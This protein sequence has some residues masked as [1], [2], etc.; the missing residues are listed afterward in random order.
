MRRL[1]AIAV[2][3]LCASCGSVTPPPAP[4]ADALTVDPKLAEK[5]CGP[6]AAVDEETVV[7]VGEADAITAAIRLVCRDV[8]QL[9]ASEASRRAWFIACTESDSACP[10]G[11]RCDLAAGVC[12]AEVGT[13][14]L[15]CLPGFADCN[16]KVEDGCEAD[17]L[18]EA[19]HCGECSN[20]CD[21]IKSEDPIE[22]KRGRCEPVCRDGF[23][24]CNDLPSDGCEVA[25]D[26]VSNCGKCKNDCVSKLQASSGTA[27]GQ[28]RC[29]KSKAASGDEATHTCALGCVQGRADCIALDAQ[30]P[31]T[32]AGCETPLGTLTD[33]RA[34]GD[35]CGANEKCTAEGCL[36][37]SSPNVQKCGEKL[38]SIDDEA[39]CGDCDTD[40]VAAFPHQQV[41]CKR[42]VADGKGKP[43]ATE[44]G[45]C[46]FATQDA[47]ESPCPPYRMSC[48]GIDASCE[49]TFVP[50]VNAGSAPLPATCRFTSLADDEIVACLPGFADCDSNPKDCESPYE[51]YVAK[52]D[53]QLAKAPAACVLKYRRQV[54][55]AKSTADCDPAQPGCE[56]A[57]VRACVARSDK[58]G[59]ALCEAGY[60]DCEKDVPGCETEHTT[61]QHCGAC[62][63]A[64]APGEDGQTGALCV[65][66][67]PTLAKCECAPGDCPVQESTGGQGTTTACV[68]PTT[69]D[70]CGACGV[71]CTE[72]LQN[73]SASCLADPADCATCDGA[74]CRLIPGAG[75]C[76]PDHIDCDLDATNGCESTTNACA[77]CGPKLDVCTD[78]V[79]KTCVDISTVDRCG[80]CTNDC[81]TLV[82]A[83]KH[84]AAVDCDPVQLQCL[85]T[86]EDGF[87][88]CETDVDGCETN[89]AAS[90]DHCG[91]C[92]SPC[93]ANATCATDEFGFVG[94]QCTGGSFVCPGNGEAPVQWEDI[95]RQCGLWSDVDDACGS[96][97][98][99]C[100]AHSHCVG[101]KCTCDT[102]Y[103]S[104]DGAAPE[105]GN[106][107]ETI[108]DTDD[109]HCGQCNDPCD[110]GFNCVG[111]VCFAQ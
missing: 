27:N 11:F 18:T 32:G 57:V 29:E 24:N 93:S 17:L 65:A 109:L 53:G 82:G 110:P 19:A 88:D 30:G 95:E 33:C 96:G 72:V 44:L 91:G 75:H 103:D 61:P 66:K 1:R 85:L 48:D 89:L 36:D 35:A 69:L 50:R 71:K 23:A 40:C 94:C 26:S 84:V 74:Q 52:P 76:D 15:P 8:A 5:L 43:T 98:D 37:G 108:L 51:A 92:Q 38:V 104:C 58:D 86:C 41:D 47:K 70:H 20:D 39:T 45:K 101:G 99:Q 106:G 102:G 97:C 64:C 62:A 100:K 79:P 54:A 10:V 13:C 14:P 81:T 4:A 34:C 3:L 6:C 9:D 21:T 59:E 83:G 73:L 80:S 25:I 77:V 22:C 105:V 90:P 87:E 56:T 68:A 46:T 55:C 49:A 78:D 7:I 60:L 12:T 67:S 107:C 111:G 16:G 42:F 31:G 63:T 28:V 2:G